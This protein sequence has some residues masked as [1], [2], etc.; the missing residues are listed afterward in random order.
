[1]APSRMIIATFLM[2]STL[3][4][5]EEKSWA[6]RTADLVVVG[7][8][9]LSSYFLSLDGIHINGN[10]VPSEILYGPAQSG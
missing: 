4:P 7:K 10:I 2:A 6:L 9:Q 3:L 1:M 8:L 5:A